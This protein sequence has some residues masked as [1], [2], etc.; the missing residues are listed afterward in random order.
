[1]ERVTFEEYEAAKAAVL[2][3]KEYEETSSMENNVIHKQYVCKDGMQR[4]EKPQEREYLPLW[5]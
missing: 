5:K 2:Y 4:R 3:G 1:M